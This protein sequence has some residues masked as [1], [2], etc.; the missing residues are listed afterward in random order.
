[1]PKFC[2]M[3]ACPNR[4]VEDL[5]SCAVL[6]HR[7]PSDENV[8]A[9]WVAF[10]NKYNRTLGWKP[11]ATSSARLCE[12]HFEDDCYLPSGRLL[13]TAVPTISH[14]FTA[15]RAYH[16]HLIPRMDHLALLDK[17][18][19]FDQDYVVASAELNAGDL[20]T[21]VGQI[22]NASAHAVS[23]NSGSRIGGFSFSYPQE[24]VL[25]QGNKENSSPDRPNCSY[26][27]GN[28]GNA[29]MD[30]DHIESDE[31]SS[32]LTRPLGTSGPKQKKCHIAELT[33]SNFDT[34]EKAEKSLELVKAEFKR[35][36][37]KVSI[38]QYRLRQA[39][40]RIKDLES[41][42]E[43]SGGETC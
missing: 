5:N 19:D 41:A 2:F 17:L 24:Q 36:Q 43:P 16:C 8:R 26:D 22:S 33:L 40:K 30:P 7:F 39:Q 12:A 34:R 1:M 31:Y 15:E 25:S 13:R 9:K 35:S 27:Y 14:K 38:L 4:F 10:V 20:L 18:N 32:R 42:P 21:S 29:G 11:G 28:E 3:Y 37:H 23:H 6:H